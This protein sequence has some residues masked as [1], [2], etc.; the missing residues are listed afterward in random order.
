METCYLQTLG[1]RAAQASFQ[2]VVVDY[3]LRRLRGLPCR[4]SPAR[5]AASD[6]LHVPPG[7]RRLPPAVGRA[8]YRRWQGHL[9]S[10]S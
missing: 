5:D 10:A 7:L 8:P 4:I 6:W 1:A 3:R 9:A 2:H